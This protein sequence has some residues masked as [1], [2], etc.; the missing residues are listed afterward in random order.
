M[1]ATEAFFVCSPK[2]KLLEDYQKK[3]AEKIAELEK[4][5]NT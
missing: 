5:Q 1:Q 2:P 4:K 3:M